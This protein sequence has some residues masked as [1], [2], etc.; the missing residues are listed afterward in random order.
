[1]SNNIETRQ[2]CPICIVIIKCISIPSSIPYGPQLGPGW[3]PVGPNWGPFG[4]AAWDMYVEVG[5]PTMR[6]KLL[7]VSGKG[8][9]MGIKTC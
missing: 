3:A 7:L 9:F 5:V 8:Q 4:N 1:M 2:C 6:F